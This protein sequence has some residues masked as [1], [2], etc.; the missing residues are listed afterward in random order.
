MPRLT[1]KTIAT[2]GQLCAELETVRTYGYS[3]DDE[4]H[5]ADVR[6]VAA[7]IFNEHG[8]PAAAVS[9]S[10]P[11]MRIADDRWRLSEPWFIG[12][13]GRSPLSSAV[14]CRL[15]LTIPPLRNMEPRVPMLEHTYLPISVLPWPLCEFGPY[16]P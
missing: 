11:K 6:C 5:T 2:I 8:L 13:L 15:R 9:L 10:G 12:L 4:E 3:T 14:D 16:G 7:A 1:S